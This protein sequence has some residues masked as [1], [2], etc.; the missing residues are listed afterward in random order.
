M[1]DEIYSGTTK[2]V[3]SVI[4]DGCRHGLFSDAGLIPL[5]LFRAREKKHEKIFLL[6]RRRQIG[7]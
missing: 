7:S 2:R 4:R 5:A 6:L 3:A 1:E